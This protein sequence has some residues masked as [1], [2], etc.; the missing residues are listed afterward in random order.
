MFLISQP[1]GFEI[2][3]LLFAL[4]LVLLPVY[5]IVHLLRNPME[6]SVKR[7]LYVLLIIFV[8]V[9]GSFFYL[10]TRDYRTKQSHI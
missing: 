1:K 10:I 2:I 3:I 5:C 7:L 4:T 9:L 6:D 8:P